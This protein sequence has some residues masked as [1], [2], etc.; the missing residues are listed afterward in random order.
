MKL[1][2]YNIQGKE[3]TALVN[4]QLQ[5]GTYEVDWNASEYPSGVYL[6]KLT[7]GDFSETK[8]MVL[9]K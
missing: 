1:V 5:P 2:I 7:V 9:L 4:Q 8:R 6:Y 3:I